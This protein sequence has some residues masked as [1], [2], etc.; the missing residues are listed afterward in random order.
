MKNIKRIWGY[1]RF[2]IIFPGLCLVGCSHNP[3]IAVHNQTE[4]AMRVEIEG[5]SPFVGPGN[6]PASGRKGY[7]SDISIRV[8]DQIVITWVTRDPPYQEM[9]ETFN[10]SEIGIPRRIRIGTLSIKLDENSDWNFEYR[11]FGN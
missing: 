4:E 9:V 11:R 7:N 3:R 5:F 2:I 8:E 1:V 6:L 10:R